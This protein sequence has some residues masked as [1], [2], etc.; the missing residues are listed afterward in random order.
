MPPQPV[1][2]LKLR[3]HP[4]ASSI[5]PN[6]MDA[7]AKQNTSSHGGPRVHPTRPRPPTRAERRSKNNRSVRIYIR[8]CI[9][10]YM[11]R[12]N[13]VSSTFTIL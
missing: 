13:G 3:F 8:K 12:M 1:R 2:A 11:T 4:Q 5:P 10:Y 6:A 7:A 9:Y